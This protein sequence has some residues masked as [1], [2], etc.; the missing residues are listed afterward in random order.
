MKKYLQL[1]LLIVLIFSCKNK[2]II[3]KEAIGADESDNIKKRNLWM[4]AIHRAAPGT[5]WKAI[6]ANNARNAFEIKKQLRLTNNRA[7]A[8]SF[9]GGLLNGTWSERGATNIAGSV[10]AVDYDTPTNNIYTIGAGGALWRG[11]LSGDNWTVLNDDKQFDARTLKVFNKN[12]GGRRLLLS[13]QQTL[14]WSDN[15]GSTLNASAGINFPVAWGG[16]YID[17]IVVLNDAT[18]TVYVLT[19]N[20]DNVLGWAPRHYLFRSVDG[21][22]NFTRIHIFPTGSDNEVALINPY[23]SNDVYVTAVND[24]T[25]RIALYEVVGSTVTSIGSS[26]VV[27][28]GGTSPLTGVLVG[29]NLTLYILKNNV[30]LY[31]RTKNGGTWSDWSFVST[32][33]KSSWDVIDVAM[34][35]ANKLYYGEV[36][37]YKSTDGGL[38]FSTVNFWYEYYSDV[39][40]KLHADIMSMKHFRKSDNTV[41]QII[42]NHGGVA[43]SND[44]M[45]TTLNLSLSSL[46]NSQSYD[47]IT[48]TMNTNNLFSGTQDQGMQIN[49]DALTPGLLN[50]EQIISGDYGYLALTNNNTKLWGIYPGEVAY[51]TD[52]FTPGAWVEFW[53]IPGTTIPNYGWMPPLKATNNKASNDIYVAGG[54]LLGGSGSHLIKLTPSNTVPVTFATSQFSYN[55]RANSNDGLSNISSLEISAKDPGKIYIATEDGTFFYSN[56][57][58]TS[59]NKTATFNGTTGWYLYGQTILS[60]KLTS[61]LVWYGGSGYSNPG[62]FKSTNGG[63]SFTPMNNGLPQTLVHEIAANADETMLFAATDAGPY[64]Y[65]VANNTWYP[66]I[67]AI[68]PTQM[69]MAVEY[70]RSSNTVRFATY[71]RGIFDFKI[72]PNVLPISGLQLTATLNTNKTV[73][74]KWTTETEVNNNYFEVEKSNNGLS[75]S[76]LNKVNAYGNGNSSY[77][78]QYQT[79]DVQPYNKVS[80][81]RLKQVDKNGNY[82]YSNTIK[83]NVN[84]GIEIVLSPNPVKNVFTLNPVTEIKSVSLYNNAGQLIKT[85]A[86]QSKYDIGNITSGQYVLKI[87]TANNEIQNLILLKN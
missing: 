6:E 65:I 52:P 32:L 77:Q 64:V 62:V 75:F 82:M 58:G 78:Q 81:Y 40:G 57:N 14:F 47:I 73:A 86:P 49:N 15:E 76:K 39:A 41:F 37:S 38:T 72:E 28:N 50:F 55:F 61:N 34:D 1:F 13:D 33:A 44:D 27:A 69:Y 53:S 67:G 24:I 80:Y 4:E 36:D 35:D 23:N 60:S 48:D 17:N 51:F 66:M 42:N 74:V 12:G 9:A 26:L 20:W 19:H 7:T 46:N 87:V 29:G 5:N 68:T 11:P 10:I 79:V 31:K 16:N 2:S 22:L 84:S 71:G 30:D 54:N 63:V 56:D 21:G 70:I 59:W 8:E 83:V 45:A 25:N 3:H 43:A 18:N 85:F